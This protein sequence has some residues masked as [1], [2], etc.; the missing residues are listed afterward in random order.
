MCTDNKHLM[1]ECY[2]HWLKANMISMTFNQYD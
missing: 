2:R 1:L